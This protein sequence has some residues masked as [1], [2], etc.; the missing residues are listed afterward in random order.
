MYVKTTVWALGVDSF[1]ES[2][3]LCWNGDLIF[4]DIS[5][6]PFFKGHL[7]PPGYSL[8]HTHLLTAGAHL[9]SNQTLPLL[10][11]YPSFPSNQTPSLIFEILRRQCGAHFP[12]AEE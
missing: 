10:S 8:L 7:V 3:C 5:S 12:T 2:L 9:S 4:L 1:L 11:V 6:F